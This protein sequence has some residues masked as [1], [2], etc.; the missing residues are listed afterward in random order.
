[1]SRRKTP[2]RTGCRRD[3][4]RA[5]DCLEVPEGLAALLGDEI[6]RSVRARVDIT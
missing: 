6:G 4:R 2:I 3:A 1:M 5:R